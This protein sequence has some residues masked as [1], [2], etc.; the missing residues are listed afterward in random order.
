MAAETHTQ[1]TAQF[2]ETC[3]LKYFITVYTLDLFPALL[4]ETIEQFIFLS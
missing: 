2:G 1:L 4:L 3:R